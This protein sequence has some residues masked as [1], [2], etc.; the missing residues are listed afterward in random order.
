MRQA[1]YIHIPVSVQKK[2]IKA[3][4][5]NRRYSISSYI[6]FFFTF[7][8]LGWVWEVVFH[9]FLDRAFV[10]RGLLTGPWLP[11]Y[12]VGGLLIL[13]FLKPFAKRPPLLFLLIT[14]ACSVLE[15][16]AGWLLE[17]IW[18]LRW[19]DYSACFMNLNGRICLGAS[20]LFST[21]GCLLIY[22][23]APRLDDFY[24]HLSKSLRLLLCVVLSLLFIADAFHAVGHPNTGRGITLP[25]R[26]PAAQQLSSA[27]GI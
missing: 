13:I 5:Y 10:N 6:L 4:T 19:W 11:I 2:P 27:P 26:P 20:L 17:R 9:L 1:P 18:S 15:Y 8:F 16:T 3:V 7:S 12:G 22:V 21:G 24:L 14:A 25:P 23:L